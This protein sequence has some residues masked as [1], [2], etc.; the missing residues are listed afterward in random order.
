M[1][2]VTYH[3]FS[4][5]VIQYSQ[6]CWMLNF[7][8]DIIY[9][10]KNNQALTISCNPNSFE[11]PWYALYSHPRFSLGYYYYSHNPINIRQ[12]HHPIKIRILVRFGIHHDFSQIHWHTVLIRIFS[13]ARH[14][15]YLFQENGWHYILL[16]I[17]F[18]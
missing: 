12:K 15:G 1:C 16:T 11:F 13:R 9:V 18:V 14:Y 17:V 3:H 4:C 8:D 10:R 5:I 2:N 6:M 7:W